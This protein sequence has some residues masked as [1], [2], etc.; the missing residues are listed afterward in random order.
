M[1]ELSIQIN[2][3][4]F[5][6]KPAIVNGSKHNLPVLF[7]LTDICT[8]V[9]IIHVTLVCFIILCQNRAN[10]YKICFSEAYKEH[11][12]KGKDMNR[13]KQG[14]FIDTKTAPFQHCFS[15]CKLLL[16]VFFTLSLNYYK[17]VYNQLSYDQ[18][19]VHWPVN[20]NILALPS[21]IH[22]LTGT[23][24]SFLTEISQE[25]GHTDSFSSVLTIK[26][27]VHT[28]LL[29]GNLSTTKQLLCV[30]PL[31]SFHS[32]SLLGLTRIT[33]AGKV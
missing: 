3:H 4:F 21:T 23:E 10:V 30:I 16:P 1:L 15:K 24:R 32:C 7:E 27:G 31:F 17:T 8:S 6:P 9:T 22:F 5:L 2:R 12:K 19:S 18:V 13:S 29:H 28:Q 33:I 11:I 25:Y 14:S 26:E 20:S